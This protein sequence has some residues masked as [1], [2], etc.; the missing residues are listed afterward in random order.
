MTPSELAE[1]QAHHRRRL[2][3]AFQTGEQDGDVRA[4]GRTIV[5]SA[6]LAS[7]LVVIGHLWPLVHK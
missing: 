7:L 5:A 1:V 3:A 6:V 4:P 2:A